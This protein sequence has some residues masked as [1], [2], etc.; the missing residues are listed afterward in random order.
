MAT[1]AL[2]IAG[3]ALG[4]ALLPA[5][6]SVLGTTITGAVIGQQVGAMAGAVIDQALFAPSGQARA[7]TGPA[8]R[9]S[10]SPPPPR[11]RR[12]P[13]SMAARVSAGR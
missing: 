8:L 2:S 12:S 1:L 10:R 9:I 7:L 3:A 6:V 4:G 5:G 11:V 13:G